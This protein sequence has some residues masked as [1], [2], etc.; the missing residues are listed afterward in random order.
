MV[1]VVGPTIACLSSAVY[2]ILG[3]STAGNREHIVP[4]CGGKGV[5][6]GNKQLETRF[7]LCY[8]VI[9]VSVSS[10]TLFSS[11]EFS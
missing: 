9:N 4:T 8:F 3:K 2:L 7:K 6:T 10:L 11:I 5:S 1:G